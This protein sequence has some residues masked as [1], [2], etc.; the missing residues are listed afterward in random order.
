MKDEKDRPFGPVHPSP[1]HLH[2][3]PQAVSFCCTFRRVRP[4]GGTSPP[5][6]YPAPC[7]VQFG[8]SSP[9]GV[10]QAQAGAVTAAA[11]TTSIILSRAGQGFAAYGE[12]SKRGENDG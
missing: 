8:L 2:P 6:R 7:P 3:S 11:A 1:F 4:S 10:F 9:T 12:T 5:G